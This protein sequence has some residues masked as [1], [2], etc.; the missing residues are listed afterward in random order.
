MQTME[1]DSIFT[2][3][4]EHLLCILRSRHHLSKKN[5]AKEQNKFRYTLS[6]NLGQEKENSL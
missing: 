2:F 3:H 6:P 1:S 4:I 5:I